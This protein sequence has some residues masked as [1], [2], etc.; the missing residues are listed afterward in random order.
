[1][2]SIGRIRGLAAF[3]CAAAIAIAGCGSS[4]SPH[5]SQSARLTTTSTGDASSSGSVDGKSPAQLLAE[6]SDALRHAHGFTIQGVIVGGG[7]RVKLEIDEASASSVRVAFSVGTSSAQLIHTRGNSYFRANRAF[8]IAHG[9]A[10]V[11][12]LA[13]RWV[14]LPG[15]ES[16]SFTKSLGGLGPAT[17][18]RCLGED[19]GALTIAGMTT[20]G[21]QRA[22]VVKDD[23]D[24]PGASPGTLAIASSGPPYPLALTETGGQRS[25]GRIDVC[26]QGK[27]DNDR[28]M[29]TLSHFGHVSP[30]TPPSNPLE[31]SQP[32]TV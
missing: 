32:L 29:I 13:G 21:H 11:Q 2:T 26:N 17:F 28:G 24:A 18:A 27:A 8:W 25:G 14:D 15:A 5:N 23:G 9:G 22:I 30:I 19:H 7:Q 1:M 20:V 12:R 6:A 31:L 3:A 4:G 10:S 16:R